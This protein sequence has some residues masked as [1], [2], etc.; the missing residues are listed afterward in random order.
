MHDWTSLFSLSSFISSQ[1]EVAKQSLGGTRC[2]QEKCMRNGDWPRDL[3]CDE[4]FVSGKLMAT[5]PIYTLVRK[6]EREEETFF[7]LLCAVIIE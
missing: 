1:S 7:R 2:E 3:F 6:R 4:K 5:L